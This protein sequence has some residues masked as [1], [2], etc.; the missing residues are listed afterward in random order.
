MICNV[1]VL[2]SHSSINIVILSTTLKMVNHK[3]EVFKCNEY[4]RYQ[5]SMFQIAKLLRTRILQQISNGSILI[6]QYLLPF[7][8]FLILLL[9]ILFR[10]H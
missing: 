7:C 5:N 6:Y 9:I 2:N 4:Q 1:S 10:L 3:E 8:S